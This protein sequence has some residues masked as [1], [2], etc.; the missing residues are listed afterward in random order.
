MANTCFTSWFMVGPKKDVAMIHEQVMKMQKQENDAL[1]GMYRLQYCSLYTML[2]NMGIDAPDE[3]VDYRMEFLNAEP[4]Y[5]ETGDTAMLLFTSEDAWA[6]KDEAMGLL[7]KTFPK[8]RMF[9]TCE[10]TD[11]DVFFTNDADAVHFK[12]RFVVDACVPGDESAYEY[13][14]TEERLINWVNEEFSES[15][16]RQCGKTVHVDTYKEACDI[17]SVMDDISED[18][19]DD[20]CY[21]YIH[22]V[23]IDTGALWLAEA[24]E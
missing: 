6:P 8:V 1:H 18:Y 21:F 22:K 15:L 17:E 19:P 9:Y 2:K 16:N 7:K 23:K 4:K 12:D 14:E 11:N 24:G 20:D 5:E 13:F 10:E 3:G